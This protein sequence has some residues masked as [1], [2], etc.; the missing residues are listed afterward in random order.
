[1][2]FSH[3]GNDRKRLNVE[4]SAF[5]RGSKPNTHRQTHTQTQTLLQ[6]DLVSYIAIVPARRRL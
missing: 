2:L 4:F 1:M 6:K 5:E 3:L